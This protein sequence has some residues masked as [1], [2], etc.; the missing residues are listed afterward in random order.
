MTVISNLHFNQRNFLLSLALSFLLIL[1]YYSQ[2]RV[3]EE[4]KSSTEQNYKLK[5]PADAMP[6]YSSVQKSE[7]VSNPWFSISGHNKK[8]SGNLH[9][10]E[11][12]K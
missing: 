4:T 11:F 6:A 1:Y 2:N 9:V 10:L 8:S 7:N 12:G 3:N 5:F